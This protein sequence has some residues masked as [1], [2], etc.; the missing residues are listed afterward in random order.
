MQTIRAS[1]PAISR[2]SLWFV[3]RAVTL[4]PVISPINQVPM[5]P[6]VGEVINNK[7]RLLRVIGDGGMGSVY[8]ARHEMLGTSVALKFLHPELSRRAGLVQRFLQE[9][10][11]SAQIQSPHV[12]R[13]TDVD[14]TSTGL[15][16]IV[17]EYIEGRTLQKLYEDLY[18]AGQRL[19]YADALE[20][21]IQML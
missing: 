17:M 19:A 5:R 13:V 9:A 3:C 18:H 12:V 11:V 4:S 15:A 2:N 21:A 6:Q 7:Y 20:Y 8:E 1:H 16:Y 10:R 14:Q